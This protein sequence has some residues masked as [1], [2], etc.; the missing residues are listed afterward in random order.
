[1]KK[2]ILILFVFM[3]LFLF[4]QESSFKRKL[5]ESALESVFEEKYDAPKFSVYS[6]EDVLVISCNHQISLSSS[7]LAKKTDG[8]A[9]MLNNTE[10]NNF[11]YFLDFSSINVFNDILNEYEYILFRTNYITSD[12]E[13]V[14]VYYLISLDQYKIISENLTEKDFIEILQYVE[15]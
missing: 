1:M 14:P 6:K 11:K 12:L 8:I 3:P 5:C 4:S 9:L 15:N 7:D 2:L 10:Q 13:K